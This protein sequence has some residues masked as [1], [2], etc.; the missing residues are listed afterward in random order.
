M[1]MC[2][3]IYSGNKHND[4][5]TIESGPQHIQRISFYDDAQ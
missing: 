3:Y 5:S 2:I 4:I 1:S